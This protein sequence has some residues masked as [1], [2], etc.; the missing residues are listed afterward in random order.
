MMAK[1]AERQFSPI[2]SGGLN[3]DRGRLERLAV[4]ALPS[5]IAP[6]PVERGLAFGCDP[7]DHLKHLRIVRGRDDW[8]AR[9]DDPSLLKGDFPQASGRGSRYDRSSRS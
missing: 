2:S 3:V 7:L 5:E 4:V 6:D 8:N 9:L 1:Q